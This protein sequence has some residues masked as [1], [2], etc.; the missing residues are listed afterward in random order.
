M[1]SLKRNCRI[2]PFDQF[3]KNFLWI[4]ISSGALAGF[5]PICP[6]T[7]GSLEGLIIFWFFKD[8]SLV[9][10]ISLI[11]IITFLGVISS[12]ITSE[13]LQKKD[14]DIVVIDEIAGMCIGV[15]GKQS[16]L[17]FILAFI[18]FRIIDIKKP[19]PL[20]KS[21]KLPSGWGIMADDLIA[22][23]LTNLCVTVLYFIA[24]YFSLI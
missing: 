10:Q 22:G 24:K 20:K 12:T 18:I 9:T 1:L 11:L 13:L 21:E 15:V 17:E 2:L 16:I 19:F 7:W 23:I 14:P 8:F 4:F 5:L 6:G 3:E